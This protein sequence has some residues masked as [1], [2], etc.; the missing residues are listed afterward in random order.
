MI[1]L[2]FSFFFFCML[3]FAAFVARLKIRFH[4]AGERMVKMH[5]HKKIEKII[6]FLSYVAFCCMRVCVCI[7]WN[8]LSGTCIFSPFSS[9]STCVIK[10]K[11]SSYHSIVG[12]D[13]FIIFSQGAICDYF[14]FLSLSLSLVPVRYRVL[15]IYRTKK[16]IQ[17]FGKLYLWLFASCLQTRNEVLVCHKNRFQPIRLHICLIGFDLFNLRRRKK[18]TWNKLATSLAI[19]WTIWKERKKTLLLLQIMKPEYK[20]QTPLDYTHTPIKPNNCLIKLASWKYN[21]HYRS[22]LRF[23]AA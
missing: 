6:F 1:S 20:N 13:A 19:F 8:C 16:T 3:L 21:L 7:R 5:K 18:Y 23:T 9:F 15:K 12:Y 22:L 11:N 2:F 10:I 14:F 4:L 17:T